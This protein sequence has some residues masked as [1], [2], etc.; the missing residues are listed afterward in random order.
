MKKKLLI[1]TTAI[2]TIIPNQLENFILIIQKL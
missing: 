1:L 2:E